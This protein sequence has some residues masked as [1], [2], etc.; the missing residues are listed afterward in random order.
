MLMGKTIERKL[1]VYLYGLLKR[2]KL[3]VNEEKSRFVNATTESFDFLGFTFRYD[4]DLLGRKRKYWNIIPSK[5]SERK[6]RENISTLLGKIGHA[7]PETLTQKLNEK[8]RG[9]INYFSISG[10]SYPQKAKRKIR[11]YLMEKIYRYYKRKSQRKCKLYNQGAFR[12]LVGKYGLIE[13][14]TYSP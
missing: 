6:M 1:I 2:M 10:I 14:R 8:L 5:K 9:W 11:W 13:P 3:T 7:S 12:I 4:R